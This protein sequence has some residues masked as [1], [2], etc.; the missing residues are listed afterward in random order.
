MTVGVTLLQNWGCDY[1][2]PVLSPP[3]TRIPVAAVPDV[4]NTPP[5]VVHGVHSTRTPPP[6]N[7]IGL[8]PLFFV[9]LCIVPIQCPRHAQSPS[10]HGPSRRP[11][12]TSPRRC[13]SPPMPLL[14]LPND[15]GATCTPPI[16]A[17]NAAKPS[18][19]RMQSVCPSSLSSSSSL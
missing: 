1:L 10:A 16:K 18:Q 17:S 13:P 2:S 15:G 6:D 8:R 3:T 12:S 5:V 4:L 14:A 11:T 9:E 7:A 19:T